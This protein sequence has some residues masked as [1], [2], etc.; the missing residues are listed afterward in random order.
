MIGGREAGG[1]A[2][3]R[4]GYVAACSATVSETES[5]DGARG[6]LET[7]WDWDRWRY[8]CTRMYCTYGDRCA[9]EAGRR[10]DRRTHG[11]YERTEE[12]ASSGGRLIYIL[13]AGQDE[14]ERI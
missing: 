14:D 10:T 7:D 5:G 6:A 9:L 13:G 12:R 3:G 2:G 11:H 1:R 8:V 4:A